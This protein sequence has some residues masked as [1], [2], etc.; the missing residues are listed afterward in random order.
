MLTVRMRLED[1]EAGHRYLESRISARKFLLGASL[2][3]LVAALLNIESVA[4]VSDTREEILL[5]LLMIDFVFLTALSAFILQRF[6]FIQGW[7]S[8]GPAQG[9]A[10]GKTSFLMPSYSLNVVEYWLYITGYLGLFWFVWNA[11]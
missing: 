2:G 11:I 5:R 4:A 9:A 8:S 1:S 3:P 6:V 7:L 10:S